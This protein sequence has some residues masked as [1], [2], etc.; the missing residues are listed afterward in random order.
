MNLTPNNKIEIHLIQVSPGNIWFDSFD[1][2]VPCFS[3][4]PCFH[5]DF[6]FSSIL[7]HLQCRFC[8]LVCSSFV[9]LYFAQAPVYLLFGKP[10]NNLRSAVTLFVLFS[11]VVQALVCL[12]CLCVC[13]L[14]VLFVCLL[15]IWGSS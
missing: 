1:I 3:C 5:S 12:C 11:S 9:F 14:F 13:L 2:F 15:V 6:R 10:A 8:E 4:V 7:L